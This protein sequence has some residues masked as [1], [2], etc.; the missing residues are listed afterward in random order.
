VGIPAGISKGCGKGGKPALWLSMLSIP[1]HF[2][3]LF[4]AAVALS[5]FVWLEVQPILLR[6]SFRGLAFLPHMMK[7]RTM[8]NRAMPPH[9]FTRSIVVSRSMS[10]PDA[11]PQPKER[12]NPTTPMPTS[13]RRAGASLLILASIASLIVTGVGFEFQNDHSLWLE[14][15]TS[16]TLAGTASLR[17]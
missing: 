16:V 11:L 9:T 7:A 10:L 1:R 17:C 14:D 4:L 13:M 12:K 5:N 8:P 15:F 3:G 6:R 2:H